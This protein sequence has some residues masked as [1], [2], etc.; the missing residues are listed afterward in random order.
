MTRVMI[1]APHPDDAELA[2][3]ATIARMVASGWHVFVL[4]LTDG[5]PTPHGSKEIRAREAGNAT[6][7]LQITQRA[8]LELPNRYLEVNLENR[9]RL[10][11]QIRLYQPDILFGPLTPD[12]HPDHVAT[13]AL[14][15]GARFEAKLH[16]TRMAGPPHWVRQVYGYY[17]IH[18]RQHDKPSLI[19]DT[20]DFWDRKITALH[21]YESQMGNCLPDDQVSLLDRVD[22]VGR[23]FGQ[24]IGR[25]YAEP[26][27][28]SGPIA[29]A[30]IELLGDLC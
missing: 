24:C 11:E 9:R 10:A 20:T 28:S 5:E 21:A 13:A 15:D 16:K 29:I 12:D 22:A 19:V 23:Y 6:A 3:G 17:S 25:R 30:R 14:I 27:L 8:C 26:F 18:R 4:D 1:V 2:M 7:I